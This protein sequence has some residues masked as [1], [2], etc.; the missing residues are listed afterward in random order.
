MTDFLNKLIDIKISIPNIIFLYYLFIA[1][2]YTDNLISGQLQDFLRT[3]RIAK[4]IIGFISILVLLNLTGDKDKRDY[5]QTF[6]RAFIIYLI[7][8]VST[9]LDLKWNLIL[10]GGLILSYLYEQH[11]N[12]RIGETEI[13]ETLTNIYKNS[14][15][16]SFLS[17]KYLIFGLILGGISIGAYSYYNKKETQF[18]GAF[19]DVKF[20]FDG[21]RREIYLN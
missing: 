6:G 21:S 8:L 15:I 9:K 5:M 20:L 3:N 13:D 16:K 17:Q 2:N 7:F 18:G 11:L 12:F 4:H 14:K 1:N 19:D 10:I